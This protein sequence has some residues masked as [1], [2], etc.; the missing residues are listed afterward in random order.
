[1]TLDTDTWH[2]TTLVPW[3]LTLYTWH[4]TFDTWHMTPNTW[5]FTHDT[6]HM[7]L[8]TWHS[9]N[10]TLH[11]TPDTW[12]LTHDTWH[13]RIWGIFKHQNG[14]YCS[15]KISKQWQ[16][17]ASV[18]TKNHK[19]TTICWLN[20]MTMLE[21]SFFTLCLAQKHT[22]IFQIPWEL[23]FFELKNTHLSSASLGN[24]IFLC[25]KAHVYLLI[26]LGIKI[27]FGPKTHFYLLIPNKVC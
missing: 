14:G 6:L 23:N 5:H 25:P 22:F 16:S 3:H 26:P 7:T 17:D 27:F 8:D 19:S 12:N 21:K 1:M 24:E 15:D 18:T 2:M 11:M 9:T 10:G 20:N 13:R 4:L